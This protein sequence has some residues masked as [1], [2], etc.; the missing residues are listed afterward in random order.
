MTIS[1]GTTAES[2]FVVQQWAVREADRA[3]LD[4]ALEG[5]VRHIEDEHPEIAGVQFFAQWVG[6][7]AHRGYTWIEEFP[8]FEA[9]SQGTATP[10]CSAVWEPVHRLVQDGTHLRSVW[11]APLA[12]HW[13]RR[14]K[15]QGAGS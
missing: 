9:M 14:D 13:L 12:E 11:V 4:R 15:A 6:A 3:E 10:T 2:V 1:R 8:T 7:Q 5:I